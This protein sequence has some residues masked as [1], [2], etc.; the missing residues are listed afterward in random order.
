MGDDT[1]TA[2]DVLQVSPRGSLEVIR[3]AYRVLA[4]A[5][6]PDVN[7]SPQASRRMQEVNAAYEILIDPARRAEYDATH[8]PAASARRAGRIKPGRL[9]SDGPQ[10]RRQPAESIRRQPT[11]AIRRQ[12][13]MP[14]GLILLAIVA[15]TVAAL[16]VAF[17]FVAD[18]ADGAPASAVWMHQA[19]VV[20][21]QHDLGDLP[22]RA[23]APIGRVGVG[24]ATVVR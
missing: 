11:G 17:W 5:Y 2:Y 24:P 16:A 23:A 4:R 14:V 21:H 9:A 19:M 1:R 8:L 22:A 10:H 13:A 15:A 6:H 12:P 7:A 18:E 3:A 20:G